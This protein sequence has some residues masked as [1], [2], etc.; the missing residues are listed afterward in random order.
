MFDESRFFEQQ[1]EIENLRTEVSSLRD[2][3]R[4]AE[5]ARVGIA[6]KANQGVS[7]LIEYLSALKECVDSAEQRIK[8]LEALAKC[9]PS[10]DSKVD[11]P[12][13]APTFFAEGV[14]KYVDESLGALI[15]RIEALEARTQTDK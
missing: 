1:L 7:R 6:S 5:A 14:Q 8:A 13:V 3:V 12:N 10:P 11:G 9:A 2:A 15:E 4:K